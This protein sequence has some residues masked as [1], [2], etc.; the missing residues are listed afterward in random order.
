MP[1]ILPRLDKSAGHGYPAIHQILSGDLRVMP[2]NTEAL[3]RALLT[4]TG[5]AAFPL[6][7]LYELVN[8]TG[9]AAKLVR[10]FNL[11]DGS[12]SQREIVK[13]TKIDQGQFSRTLNRWV[14]AGV[15]FRLGAGR[16][17][18]LLHVYP[19]PPQPPKG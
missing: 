16:D 7:R 9:K 2:D 6:G 15:L 14:E 13:Q 10:A 17:A 1:R 8:P 3:L 18:K 19:L 4:T 5:R 12:R 11:A